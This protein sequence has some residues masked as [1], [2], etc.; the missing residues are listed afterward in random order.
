VLNASKQ[1]NNKNADVKIE[2]ILEAL[3]NLSAPVQNEWNSES[4]P[5]RTHLES[6][7][8]IWASCP[9]DTLVVIQLRRQ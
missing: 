3:E 8:N 5:F 6:V 2:E 1:V 4:V 9:S 7:L